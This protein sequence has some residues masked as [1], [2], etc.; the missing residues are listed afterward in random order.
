[1]QFK[2]NLLVISRDEFKLGSAFM[3][4]RYGLFI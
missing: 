2:A 1:M 3:V 4:K